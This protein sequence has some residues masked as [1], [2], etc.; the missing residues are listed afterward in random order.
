MRVAPSLAALSTASGMPAVAQC[1]NGGGIGRE[2]AKLMHQEA[3]TERPGYWRA[4]ELEPPAEGI[5]RRV[6]EEASQ[7]KLLEVARRQV[8]SG[9]VAGGL[10]DRL[11]LSQDRPRRG[12]PPVMSLGQKLTIL[13]DVEKAFATGSTLSRRPADHMSH[14]SI[15]NLLAWARYDANPPLF[16]GTTPGRRSGELTAAARAL[17]RKGVDG[18]PASRSAR[19]ATGAPATATPAARNTRGTSPQGRRP[20]VARPGD[21]EHRPR[22]LRRPARRTGDPKGVRG[23]LAEDAGRAAGDALDRRQRA[24]PAHPAELGDRSLA[25]LRR[26]DVQGLVK[27][28]SETLAPRSTR[29]V[30]D[31]LSRVLA[32][33]VHDRVLRAHHA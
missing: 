3:S 28:V 11:L 32:A 33:A 13:A 29:N 17:I 30:Y 22:R 9:R 25:T 4:A 20:A 15:R 26:S 10:A 8:K 14:G 7:T 18:W 12:R 2:I 23:Q 1:P 27:G 6:F 5:P 21:R 19:T 24:R 31:T 16:T